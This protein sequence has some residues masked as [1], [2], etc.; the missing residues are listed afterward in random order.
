MLFL[1]NAAELSV[2]SPHPVEPSFKLC[3]AIFLRTDLFREKPELWAEDVPQNEVE[4][5]TGFYRGIWIQG[6][7]CFA[8]L[9]VVR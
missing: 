5:K 8:I 4:Y 1:H 6:F 3:N 7:G 2:S 9:A